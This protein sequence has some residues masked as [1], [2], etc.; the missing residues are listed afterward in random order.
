MSNVLFIGKIINGYIASEDILS[1]LNFYIPSRLRARQIMFQVYYKTN[2]R[3]NSPIVRMCIDV[4]SVCHESN[5]NLFNLTQGK[6][7]K[8]IEKIFSDTE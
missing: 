1:K 4:N 6:L 7:K 2:V 3:K 8:Y 5:F